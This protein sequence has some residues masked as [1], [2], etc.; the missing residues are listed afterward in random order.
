MLRPPLLA[1]NI[2][3]VL[4]EFATIPAMLSKKT[5]IVCASGCSRRA[6][7]Y[8]QMHSSTPTGKFP[9]SYSSI[10][11]AVLEELWSQ[12]LVMD[13]H[14]YGP[15]ILFLC[16]SLLFL[17]CNLVTKTPPKLLNWNF[18]RMFLSTLSSPSFA[19]S[20]YLSNVCHYLISLSSF[21]MQ[22]SPALSF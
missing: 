13:G 21:I 7:L 20:H 8:S 14:I 9:E 18:Q 19:S 15:K 3:L 17:L 6:K 12:D 11:Q 10:Y 1:H 16:W 2:F 22:A 4:L 5:S